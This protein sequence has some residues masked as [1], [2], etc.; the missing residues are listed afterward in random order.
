MQHLVLYVLFFIGVKI[1]VT[2]LM[3]KL[4]KRDNLWFKVE[5][6]VINFRRGEYKM[7]ILSFSNLVSLPFIIILEDYYQQNL[8]F[9]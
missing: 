5:I 6:I 3:I 9:Q 7:R 1:C 4:F 2:Y 8:K